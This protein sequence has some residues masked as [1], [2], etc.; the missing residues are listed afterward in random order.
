MAK[1]SVLENSLS[2][3]IGKCSNFSHRSERQVYIEVE[4]S[5]A[6]RQMYKMRTLNSS[7]SE[8]QK[9]CVVDGALCHTVRCWNMSKPSLQ[10]F[11]R[12]STN[13]LCCGRSVISRTI[14]HLQACRTGNQT[15]CVGE[16]ERVLKR[17]KGSSNRMYEY[18]KMY[19]L[20]I[21]D[22]SVSMDS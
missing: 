20:V 6:A 1:S 14:E 12:Q 16:I 19:L 11:N 8:G 17:I 13:K 4:C 3:K 2:Y 22:Y 5:F 9:R 18:I 21:L 10:A 15:D 7:V